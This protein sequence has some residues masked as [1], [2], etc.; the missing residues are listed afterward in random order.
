MGGVRRNFGESRVSKKLTQTRAFLL[1]AL[2][3]LGALLLQLSYSM[4]VL[5]SRD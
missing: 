1:S 4:V 3:Y 5:Y 2:F